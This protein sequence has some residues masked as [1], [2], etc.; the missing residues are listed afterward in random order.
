MYFFVEVASVWFQLSEVVELL[1]VLLD[2]SAI[3]SGV[4][5]MQIFVG[6]GKIFGDF[7]V[8]FF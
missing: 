4:G 7:C 1:N 6:L 2:S 3:V 8:L 5:V